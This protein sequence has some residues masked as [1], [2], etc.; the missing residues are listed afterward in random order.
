MEKITSI[1]AQVVTYD[2]QS[3]VQ[4]TVSTE[5]GYSGTAEL[6]S[7]VTVGSNEAKLID[8]AQA[9]STINEVVSPALVGSDVLEQRQLD[10]RLMELD[11]TVDR[12][13]LGVNSLL[14]VS[15]AAARAAAAALERELYVHLAEIG[16]T[17]AALPQLVQVLIEGGKHAPSSGLTIQEFS[18]ITSIENAQAI[19]TMLQSMLTKQQVPVTVGGEGGLIAQFGQNRTALQYL[20]YAATQVLAATPRLAIDAAASHGEI[21][22]AEIEALIQEFPLVIVE[23]PIPEHD[24]AAWGS[25]TATHRANLII[26][27]DDLTVGNPLLIKDAVKQSI[28]N[29]LVLKLNQTATLSELFD[30]IALIGVGGW[31]HIL[32]HRGHETPDTF[33]VD[34]AV[35]TGA[36]FV[37]MG[38]PASPIRQ[39]KFARYTAIQQ[40]LAAKQS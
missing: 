34:L 5:H 15:L 3:T 6:P 25:F 7:G 26:A 16:R 1:T 12:S 36:R 2:N 17:E 4:A 27:A 13:H 14:P 10:E 8:P 11:G 23:D 21:A 32:S 19:Q 40:Q 31:T 18:V 39:P 20:V 35:G 22:A 30:L 9:A 38:T 28:A 24:L 37:K 33:L 29:A